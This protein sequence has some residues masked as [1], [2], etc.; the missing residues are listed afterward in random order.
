[1]LGFRGRQKRVKPMDLE[2]TFRVR[3]LFSWKYFRVQARRLLGFVFS[4]FIFLSSS[5]L[6]PPVSTP[7]LSSLHGVNSASSWF[8]VRSNVLCSYL[9]SFLRIACFWFEFLLDLSLLWGEGE[10][11]ESSLPDLG[12]GGERRGAV[13]LRRPEWTEIRWW[14]WKLA[15]GN[16][17][18]LY[19]VTVLGFD[20]ELY[21]KPLIHFFIPSSVPL[22]ICLC[23]PSDLLTV[24]L[25]SSSWTLL[26][27]CGL[28][29]DALRCPVMISE[30]WGPRLPLILLFSS[31]PLMPWIV[32]LCY[33]ELALFFF[34]SNTI[35]LDLFI[36]YDEKL[37]RLGNW[38]WRLGYAGFTKWW[39]LNLQ[40]FYQVYVVRPWQ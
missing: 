36:A 31:E 23:C 26:P 25:S 37:L 22:D 7:N 17:V 32:V 34:F 10:E 12:E 29:Y 33:L 28:E 20:D 13:A 19:F 40:R 6:R 11:V 9:F 21:W 14:S 24:I 1:M 16:L 2:T 5:S 39:G 8:R 27:M 18:L 4:I 30:V 35:A 38:F 15:W 3:H